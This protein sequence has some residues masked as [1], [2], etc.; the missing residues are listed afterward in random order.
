[1]QEGQC[2]VARRDNKLSQKMRLIH[3]AYSTGKNVPVVPVAIGPSD[4]ILIEV[5]V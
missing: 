3:V 2:A 5:S 4:E 1:L